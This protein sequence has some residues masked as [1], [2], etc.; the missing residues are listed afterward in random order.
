MEIESP[1]PT[2]K[3]FI[4]SPNEDD[5][6]AT[7][8]E[9][10][11]VIVPSFLY[12]CISVLL[13]SSISTTK[14]SRFVLEFFVLI[15]P[16]VLGMTLWAE[17]TKLILVSLVGIVVSLLV[18]NYGKFSVTSSKTNDLQT[19]FITNARSTINTLSIIAILAVDFKIFPRHFGKTVT[20]GYS[21]MDTGVGLYVYSNGIVSPEALNKS[22]SISKSLKSSLPLFVVGSA[23]FIL[24][25]LLSYH[26]PVTEYGVHWNFFITLGVTKIF[27][28]FFLNIFSVKYI[29]INAFL[30]VFAH[31]VLLTSG[32][33]KFVFENDNDRETFVKANKEGIVSNI[34]YVALYL[35]SVY[36]GYFLNSKGRKQ[37]SYRLGFNI[38]KGAFAC[39]LFSLVLQQLFGISRRLA[40]ASYCFWILFLGIFMTGLFYALQIIQQSIF[41]RK[42]VYTPYIFEAINYNGLVF[43]LVGNILTG[44]INMSMYT[45]DRSD[46]VALLIISLY[47]FVNCGFVSVLYWK[48]LKLKLF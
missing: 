41:G 38:F 5:P 12:T 33:E 47:I 27:T 31:Q 48:T 24:T 6:N 16:L 15:L 46:Y 44:F 1:L 37:T 17:Y 22:N 10:L 36:F 45:T 18:L 13:E 43:F 9:T 34:G 21:L 25:K 35:F 29:Y 2:E 30:L 8:Y 28:S 42:G 19:F 7:G 11:L 23:R 26:V 4:S 3:N 39:L 40:N 14:K 20:F 32:L